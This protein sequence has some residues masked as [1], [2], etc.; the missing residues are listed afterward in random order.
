MPP[1]GDTQNEDRITEKSIN[2]TL[3]ILQIQIQHL[4]KLTFMQK[5]KIN[6]FTF[7]TFS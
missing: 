5:K 1:L 2:Q 6:I 7:F 3:K 4:V